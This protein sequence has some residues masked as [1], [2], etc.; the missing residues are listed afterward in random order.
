ML[1]ISICQSQFPEIHHAASHSPCCCNSACTIV[2]GS[3]STSKAAACTGYANA[4]GTN[5][6][7]GCAANQV[8]VSTPWGV[9]ADNW[10]NVYFSDEGHQYVRVIYAGA[11]TVNGVANPAT[12]M[13]IAANTSLGITTPL[14]AGDVYA[15]A[16]G[17]TSGSVGTC[18]GGATALSSN[19]SGCPATDSYV[20]GPYSPAVDSAGNVFIP[21][22]RGAGKCHRPGGPAGCEGERH[23]VPHL[24]RHELRP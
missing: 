21:G 15:L 5:Y 24:Q 4:S 10:G 6:G 3:F 23:F 16:G 13:I 7:D 18:N 12:A 20:K 9:V 11:T 14:V 17:L 8:G 19:G 22:V 2:S 1:Q